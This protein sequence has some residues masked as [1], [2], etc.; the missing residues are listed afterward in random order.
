MK[1]SQLFRLIPI[2]VFCSLV[3]GQFAHAQDGA[4]TGAAKVATTDKGDGPPSYYLLL[5]GVGAVLFINSR[6]RR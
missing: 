6:R 4:S 1:K 2:L 5:A 3:A